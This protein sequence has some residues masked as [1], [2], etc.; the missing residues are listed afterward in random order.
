MEENVNMVKNDVEDIYRRTGGRSDPGAEFEP[1]IRMSDVQV[2]IVV[3]S[4]C[5]GRHKGLW[6]LAVALHKTIS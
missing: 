5:K 3:I 2:R 1:F 4:Q 6:T